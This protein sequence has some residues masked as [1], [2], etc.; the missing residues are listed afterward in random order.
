MKT[1]LFR[2]KMTIMKKVLVGGVFDILHYGHVHFLK[3]AKKLGNHLVVAIESDTNVARIK[4]PGR[5]IHN[6]KQRKEVL[7]AL[8]FVDEVIILKNFMTDA[9]YRKLV[10]SV[11]P[12]VIAVTE[13]DPIL[14]KKMSHA[15][16]IGAKIIKI[17]KINVAS[18]SKIAKLL[19]IE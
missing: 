11:S 15:K 4:G 3:K 8:S 17:P 18:T 13:G 5:P 16:H 10:E 19:E 1:E 9:D 7:K 12:V 6:Q 2:S 14:E